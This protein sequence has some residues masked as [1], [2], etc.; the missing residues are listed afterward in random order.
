MREQWRQHI[1]RTCSVTN[2]QE[3]TGLCEGMLMVTVWFAA[4]RERV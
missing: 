1:G 2:W 3:R 4:P